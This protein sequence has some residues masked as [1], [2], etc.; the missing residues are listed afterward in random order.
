MPVFI[1]HHA[2]LQDESSHSVRLAALRYNDANILPVSATRPRSPMRV[3]MI[4]TENHSSSRAT[5]S[6]EQFEARQQ[7][8][9]KRVQKSVDRAYGS[10]ENS[11]ESIQKE[12]LENTTTLHHPQTM[13]KEGDW[14]SPMRHGSQ[15]YPRMMS[16]PPPEA[17]L[18][19]PG[20]SE[21]L[22][23][24]GEEQAAEMLAQVPPSK[25]PLSLLRI[26]PQ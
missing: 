7:E 2:V 23:M 21:E 14:T 13:P 24:G 9:L 6:L 1:F 12:F 25:T 11:I 4:S 15:Y 16:H 17:P 20:L 26:K 3:N 19:S 22:I 10:N 8:R 5:P 18:F